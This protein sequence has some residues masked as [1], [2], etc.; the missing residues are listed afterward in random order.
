MTRPKKSTSQ[1]RVA[2]PADVPVED[3]LAGPSVVPPDKQFCPDP[4]RV[5]TEALV[6]RLHD[7]L[8]QIDF[9]SPAKRRQALEQLAK[10]AV[11]A[12]AHI[13]RSREWQLGGAIQARKTTD[14]QI[15]AAFRKE[16]DKV[17]R[18]NKSAIVRAIAEGLGV[19]TSTIWKALRRLDLPA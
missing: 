18:K 6:S 8:I 5:P 10:E 17:P 4:E 12:L 15:A 3:L 13:E 7:L 19:S 9:A 14:E 16:Q 11:D 1:A 2:E